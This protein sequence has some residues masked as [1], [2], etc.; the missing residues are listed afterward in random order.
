MNAGERSQA[1]SGASKVACH[2]HPSWIADDQ[3]KLSI[4]DT[5]TWDSS[6]NRENVHKTAAML[7]RVQKAIP[8]RFLRASCNVV[9]VVGGYMVLARL[10]IPTQCDTGNAVGAQSRPFHVPQ[11]TP[12]Y[13]HRRRNVVFHCHLVEPLDSVRD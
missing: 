3:T 12:R 8:V 4:V 11:S 5:S 2:K 9:I 1:D 7:N 10:G 13:R 6:I